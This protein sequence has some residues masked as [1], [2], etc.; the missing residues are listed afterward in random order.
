VSNGFPAATR[1]P[2]DVAQFKILDL[3][4]VAYGSKR[5][6]ARIAILGVGTV[7]VDYF[8]PAEKPPFVAPRS[9]RAKFSDKF[10][11]CANFDPPFAA[12]VLAAVAAQLAANA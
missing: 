4:R 8:E 9:I 11:R 10:E 3:E 6:T 2:S 5:A 12:A 7:D 1:G